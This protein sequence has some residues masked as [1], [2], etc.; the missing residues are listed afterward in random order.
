MKVVGTETQVVYFVILQTDA[1]EQIP[2]PVSREDAEAVQSILR[3][4]GAKE[5][6]FQNYPDIFPDAPESPASPL[7]SRPISRPIPKE[8]QNVNSYMEEVEEEAPSL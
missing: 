2:V 7:C 1:G 4:E 5:K 8:I 3:V 6:K